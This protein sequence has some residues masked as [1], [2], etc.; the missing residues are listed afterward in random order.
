M[1]HSRPLLLVA[2]A[3]V[4]A[5]AC[6]EP[7]PFIPQI[8]NTTF[9]PSLGVDLEAST[10]TELGV[11]YRDIVVGGG[12]IVPAT[13][14]GDTIEVRYTGYLRNAVEFDSN[15]DAGD[16]A[17]LYVAGT[18]GN[19]RAI[20]GFDD[21]VRGM[22]IGGQRQIIIPPHLGYGSFAQEGIPPYSILVFNVT[23]IRIG[24]PVVNPTVRVP[25]GGK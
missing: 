12:A 11:Y 22:R 18:S 8:E 20:L 5:T 21:G 25:P 17:F 6:L 14:S 4:V 13:D 19:Q 7:S 23:L 16:P 24:E 1:R 9:E 10:R 3:A 15:E 2:I